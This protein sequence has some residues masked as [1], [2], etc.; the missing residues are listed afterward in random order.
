MILFYILI[1]KLKNFNSGWIL[2]TW[3]RF[4]ENGV[5]DTEANLFKLKALIFIMTKIVVFAKYVERTA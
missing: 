5:E 4:V 1:S 2:L 3:K